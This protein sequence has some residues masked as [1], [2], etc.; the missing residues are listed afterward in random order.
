MPKIIKNR[1]TDSRLLDE[2][3]MND[4]THE[5]TIFTNISGTTSTVCDPLLRIDAE[6]SIFLLWTVWPAH[7]HLTLPCAVWVGLGQDA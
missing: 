6:E 2:R 3:L 7:T 4:Q 1:E 5:M